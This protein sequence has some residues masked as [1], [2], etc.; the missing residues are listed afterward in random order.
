MAANDNQALLLQ[1]SADLSKLQKKFAQDGVAIVNAG[2]D[3]MERR[4]KKAAQNIEGS[5]GKIDVGKAFS[6]V[7]DSARLATLE[8]GGARLRVF[9]SALEPLGPLGLAAA[10]GVAALGLSLA[11]AHEAVEF[12]DN[13]FKLAKNAHVTTD[14]LQETQFALRLAGGNAADASGAL[15]SFSAKLGEAQAGLP[16]AQRA[17][18]EL[19]FT[20]AQI[21]G[22]ADAG[23][24]LDAVIQRIGELKSPAQKDAVIQQ[25]GLEQ[26]KPLIEA[27]VEKMREFRKEA[28]ESGNVMDAF[29]IKKGHELN[30][31]LESLHGKID[32]QLKSAF[33]ELGP[34]LVGLAKIL[35]DMATFAAQIAA[36]FQSIGDRPSDIL[37]E[38]KAFIE[39]RDAEDPLRRLLSGAHDKQT[40]GLIDMVLGARQHLDELTPDAANGHRSLVDQ[41]KHKQGPR[42]DTAERLAAINA[43]LDGATRAMLEA[44][45]GLT[46]NIEERAR[47]EGLAIDA[48]LNQ[49]NDRL[50]KEKAAL[51]ADKGFKGDRERANAEIDLTR[52][53]QQRAAEAKKALLGQQTDFA[54]EDQ[55]DDTRK[56][57]VDAVIAQ[58]T[59]AAAS[60]TT[61]AERT[62][63]ERDILKLKQD[64]F[65]HE[66]GKKL[67]RQVQTGEISQAVADQRFAAGLS[68][69]AAE[70]TQFDLAHQ[71]P[72]QKY[73]K[74]LQDIDTEISNISVSALESL[75]AGLEDAMLHATNLGEVARRVF[76]QMVADLAAAEI[77][78]NII[79][80]FVQG[81]QSFLSH[82]FGGG[83]AAASS[84]A[85][86]LAGLYA[87]GTDS[88]TGGLSLVGERGPELV[89][90]PRGTQV[91][92]NDILRS[93][94][95]RPASPL[96]GAASGDIYQNFNIATPNADSFRRGQR[97]LMRQAKFALGRA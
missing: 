56:Q 25:L 49:Q 95:H 62:K 82:L 97:Q 20:P 40:T 43:A 71:T 77:K 94:A 96:P 83:S 31:E 32:V 78:K 74:G 59:A 85:D 60:A 37:R 79:A 6:R 57:L 41:T 34:I 67:S 11:Q 46:A 47:I 75:S 91:I 80:P 29:L 17:F 44:Q 3:A 87:S 68:T 13:L 76:A 45:K 50:N 66:L 15:Q 1:I 58:L 69:Q 72:L 7:F 48:E 38:Q 14:E 64:E 65:T 70:H 33:I 52:V 39:K 55:L 9:G 12:A 84:G 88:A 19:G 5:L 10:A 8:Q 53:A 92:P 93:L 18:K 22:F 54:L 16:R 42:D 36:S 61:E 21:K 30:E 90:L 23:A 35:A 2:S 28:Q 4:A 27:G 86:D 89:N 24:G 51:A 81:G 63:I 73:L 26:M